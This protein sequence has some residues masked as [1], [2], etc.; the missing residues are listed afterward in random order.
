[1][2]INKK[3]VPIKELKIGDIFDDLYTDS[4]MRMAKFE[5]IEKCE[6]FVKLKVF[7]E[8]IETHSTEN[9][10]AGIELSTEEKLKKFANDIAELKKN[11]Q[12]EI[13]FISTEIGYHE[14]WNSWI[15]TDFCDM[16][17]KCISNNIKIIGHCHLDNPLKSY[18]ITLD[19]G[20]IAEDDIGNRFWCH[21]SSKWFDDWRIEI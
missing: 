9:C 4:S 19:I 17:M 14:M 10:Y 11:I 2:L 12:N 18:G 21:A 1:M 7:N 15:D 3:K 20:I 8:T 16:A 5:V 6:G 13:P